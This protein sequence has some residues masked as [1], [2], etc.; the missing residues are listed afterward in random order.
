MSLGKNS[1]TRFSK[2]ISC[3]NHLTKLSRN[4]INRVRKVSVPQ[5][6]TLTLQKQDHLNLNLIH[7][8]MC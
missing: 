4:F 6:V 7:R 3:R 1:D 5:G 2:S 8:L